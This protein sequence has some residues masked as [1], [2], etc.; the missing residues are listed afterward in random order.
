VA[1][2]TLL[3]IPPLYNPFTHLSIHPQIDVLLRNF[4]FDAWFYG[5]V[6][7]AELVIP[8]RKDATGKTYR[9]EPL[10]FRYK[11]C[12]VTKRVLTHYK[13]T[14]SDAQAPEKD[15]WGPWHWEIID[16]EDARV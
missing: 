4:D 15:E 7:L 12:P 16:Y 11:W 13:A 10:V 8:E 14:L 3:L 2:L 1:I 9:L 5:H 6:K